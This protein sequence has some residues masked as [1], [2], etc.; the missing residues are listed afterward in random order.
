MIP[1]ITHLQAENS[2]MICVSYRRSLCFHC[3][4]NRNK[5]SLKCVLLN[6]KW[7]ISCNIQISWRL[8]F[9]NEWN[10]IWYKSKNI[11]QYQNK[12]K[13]PTA[14]Y[15]MTCRSIVSCFYPISIFIDSLIV[16]ICYLTYPVWSF[17]Y[18]KYHHRL[19]LLYCL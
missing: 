4:R 19:S 16:N 13:F 3:I 9:S 17:L 1:R 8:Y 6:N 12:I 15:L 10:E 5:T 14:F 18:W 2:N 7:D 11:S